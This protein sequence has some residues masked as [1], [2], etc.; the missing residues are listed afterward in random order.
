MPKSLSLAHITLSSGLIHH[1]EHLPLAVS[2][3][4]LNMSKT[5][6]SNLEVSWLGAKALNEDNL[7]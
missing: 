6:Y 3:L 5:E 4:K 2:H 7:G 1:I